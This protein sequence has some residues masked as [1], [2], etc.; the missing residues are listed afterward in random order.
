MSNHR[1]GE[2]AAV[3]LSG[4]GGSDNETVVEEVQFVP[5]KVPAKIPLVLPNKGEL[6]TIVYHNEAQ[7]SL[8]KALIEQAKKNFKELEKAEVNQLLAHSN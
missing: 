1:E 2:A 3:I 6:K 7:Y 8:R 4:R 5:E